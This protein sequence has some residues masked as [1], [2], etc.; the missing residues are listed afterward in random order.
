[1]TLEEDDIMTSAFEPFDYPIYD[2]FLLM[3]KNLPTFYQGTNYEWNLDRHIIWIN[4]DGDIRCYSI[5]SS[6]V[7]V[8]A[9]LNNALKHSKISGTSFE[10]NSTI[11]IYEWDNSNKEWV[12]SKAVANAVK[13]QFRS[14]GGIWSDFDIYDVN[15]DLYYE[16]GISYSYKNALLADG[17]LGY[18]G[19]DSSIGSGSNNAGL[20]N[21]IIDWLE[22][23]WVKLGEV[24]SAISSSISD[25]GSYLGGKLDAIYGSLTIESEDGTTGRNLFDAIADIVSSIVDGFTDLGEDIAGV[26]TS[27]TT[28]VSDIIQSIADNIADVVDSITSAVTEITTSI[29]DNVTEIIKSIEQFALDVLDWF[30]NFFL[31]LVDRLLYLFVPADNYFNNTLTDFKERLPFIGVVGGFMDN[32]YNYIQTESYAEAPSISVDLSL[33]EGKYNYGVGATALDLSWYG[34]YKPYVDM[35]LSAFLWLVY[36][37]ILYKRIPDIIN[38]AGM[39]TEMSAQFSG[40]NVEQKQGQYRY[41]LR[42]GHKG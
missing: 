3:K 37:W 30:D 26:V 41:N 11:L 29:V 38:G 25:L 1:M 31:E 42:R 27:I 35:F 10:G 21:K 6:R 33:A 12:F 8:E 15:G 18:D 23:I 20:L 17:S 40:V 7:E 5:D 32:M 24:V 2:D 4:N 14:D 16:A 28:A 13:A 39:V 34:R 36:L 9:D 19:S 22:R